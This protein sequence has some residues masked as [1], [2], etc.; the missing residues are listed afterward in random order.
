MLIKLRSVNQ[1]KSDVQRSVSRHCFKTRRKI[2]TFFSQNLMFYKL[3]ANVYQLNKFG[4]YFSCGF[5]IHYTLLH[6]TRL[7]SITQNL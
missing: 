3:F 2:K 6:V 4:Y 1:I 5:S 7:L